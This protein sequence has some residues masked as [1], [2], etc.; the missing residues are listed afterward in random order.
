M[1]KAYEGS[2]HFNLAVKLN[3]NA[4]QIY[5][6]DNFKSTTMHDIAA[7]TVHQGIQARERGLP[8]P[9]PV[10]VDQKGKALP[11]SEWPDKRKLQFEVQRE[12]IIGE[13]IDHEQKR[14][15]KAD[16]KVIKGLRSSMGRTQQAIRRAMPSALTP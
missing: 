11:Y 6:G 13:Y 5:P 3:D 16:I 7:A 14:G 8:E 15:T 9:F 12:R 2:V 4:I 10:I 1:T